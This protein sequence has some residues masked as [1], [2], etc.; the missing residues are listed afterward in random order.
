[1]QCTDCYH[2]ADTS[3]SAIFRPSLIKKIN[4]KLVIIL[5]M[6]M[7]YFHTAHVNIR[8]HSN[9]F[10]DQILFSVFQKERIYISMVFTCITIY[11]LSKISN[12][13]D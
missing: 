2:D 12:V 9:S 10:L 13:F 3:L 8:Y 4:A 6:R 7:Q 5:T 11:M 1:M